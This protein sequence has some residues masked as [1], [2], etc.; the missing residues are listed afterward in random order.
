MNRAED[1]RGEKVMELCRTI[2]RLHR[3]DKSFPAERAFLLA[4]SLYPV[5]MANVIL[6]DAD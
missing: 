1:P 3:K 4:S 6:S 5:E 2:W